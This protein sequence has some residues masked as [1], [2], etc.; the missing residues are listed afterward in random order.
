MTS[1]GNAI[2]PP[3]HL[4][5]TGD[6]TVSVDGERGSWIVGAVRPV[7]EFSHLAE[8]KAIHLLVTRVTGGRREVNATSMWVRHDRVRLVRK[9][10]ADADAMIALL[11]EDPTA[12]KLPYGLAVTVGGW[13]ANRVVAL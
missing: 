1:T 13:S 2:T 10:N 9:G 4:L 3:V 11:G 12:H 5:I 6:D 8:H 7:A